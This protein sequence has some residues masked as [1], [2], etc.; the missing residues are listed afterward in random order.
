MA[1][2]HLLARNLRAAG[3]LAACLTT[4]PLAAQFDYDLEKRTAAR[5]GQNLVLDVANAPA[6]S[7][8]LVIPSATNGPT[9]LSLVD[10]VDPRV[11]AVG[12]ELLGVMSVLITDATGNASYSVALPNNPSISGYELHWQTASLLF[13]ATLVGELSN[14]VV[15]LTGSPDTGVVA[16]NTLQFARALSASLV[17]ADNNNSAGDVLV[18]GGGAGTLTAATGLASTERWDF[19]RMAVTAGPNMTT[20]RALHST[21]RLNDGRVLLIGGA[22][23][24]GT[25]LSSCEI[26]DPASNSFTA[27]G[28]MG[29]PRIL[30]GASILAD[31]RVMVAGGTSTLTPDVTAAIT[32]TLQSAEIFNPATGT[33]SN[34]QNIGG[35]RLGPALTLLSTGQVMVSGGIAVTIFFGLPVAASSTTAVQLW[36]PASSSW[37]GGS[38][39]S[40]GRAGH[41]YN[42]V[43]LNDGR[44]LM[45]GGVNVPSLLSAATSAPISGAEVYNPTTNSW[46][47]VNMPTARALHSATLLA[48]GRVATCGGAQ[49]TLTTPTSIANVDVFN[50][51][52]NT[53][54]SAPAL[55]GARASHSANLMPDGTL[56]LFGGQGATMSLSS[57]ETLRF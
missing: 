57:I 16:P 1:N 32:G 4:A 50:P 40:Q 43:T 52:S 38:S 20:A 34:T 23:Q 24:L 19:R 41:Q 12:V 36:T 27:T 18:T 30:H 49:G 44:V 48:D 7:F 5:L 6:T 35:R 47:T 28:N 55:T 22:D 37:S 13:G 21:V 33:W 54:T 9:P 14:D 15:T 11:L 29:T 51:T 39:M 42:Q 17:D 3:L 10:P 8:V 46:Q 2:N 53:W 45:T 25:V 31:G 26:Y 56:V